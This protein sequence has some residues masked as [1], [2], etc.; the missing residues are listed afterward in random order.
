[1]GSQGQVKERGGGWELRKECE[2]RG[3]PAAPSGVT[4]QKS[5][6]GLIM[7]NASDHLR[8][9]ENGTKLRRMG[10]P[11]GGATNGTKAGHRRCGGS[12]TA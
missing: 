4:L 6:F 11:A 8:C 9:E 12:L 5:I 10:F 3:S 2:R 1:M 7:A